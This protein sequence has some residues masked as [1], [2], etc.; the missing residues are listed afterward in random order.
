MVDYSYV[1]SKHKGAFCFDLTSPHSRSTC[2]FGAVIIESL[3]FRNCVRMPKRC[4]VV[5]SCHGYLLE[6]AARVSV[7]EHKLSDHTYV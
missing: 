1:D 2:G 4:R 7:I 5:G 3:G 6:I